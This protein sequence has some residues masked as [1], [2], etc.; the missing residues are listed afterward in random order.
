MQLFDDLEDFGSFD[1]AV[2]GDVRD[3]YTGF[4]AMQRLGPVQ[5]L[6]TSAMP[7]EESKPVFLVYRYDEIAEVLRDNQTFSSSIIINVFGDV[8]GKHVMLGMDEPEH[9]RYRSLVSA[10]FTQRA[11]AR[12]QDELVE[13]VANELIDRFAGRGRAEL[14]R[15][16]T[17]PYPTQIIAG[18]LGLPRE[19]YPQFQRWSISLLSFTVNRERGIAASKA[20]QEYF[21][22]ILA[23]RR[24]EPRDDLISTLARAEIDGEQLSDDEIY[25]FLRLLLPAGVETTYRSTGNLLFGLLSNP[26]QLDA[27]RSDRSLV[28]QAI[29]EAVRWEAPLLTITRVAARDTELAGVAIPAGSAVM[30]MLGAANHDEERYPEPHR[31]DIF[32]APT[33]HISFG[34]GVHVCLGMHLARL[35]MSVALNLLLDRLPGL[36]LDPA[37]DDPHIRGGVFRS[38]TSLPV[39]FGAR[40]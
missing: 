7:H 22:P 3:P 25:S 24:Q 33:P 37:G 15:E 34:H 30:P 26:D 4:A 31:F 40:A 18:L 39:L 2:S 5:R 19:D 35:E 10:A 20:L 17:F 11:L 9:R 16:F 13:R 28:P 32:R 29:E 21:A 8:F 12:R 27:V 14:V 1:D 6:E 38:P 23:A 36:R